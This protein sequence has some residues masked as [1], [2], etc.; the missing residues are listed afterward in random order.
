MNQRPFDFGADLVIHSVTKYLSGHSDLIQ[1]AVI[2]RDEAVFAPVKFLQNAIGATASPFDCWLTLRGLKTLS[3]RVRRH[4]E[5]ALAVA[6]A[7]E[8]HPAV[9]R[10]HYPGLASH[11]G[12]AIAKRQMTGFGGVV[13]CELRADLEATKRFVSQRRFFKLGESLGGVKSLVCHPASMTHASI[14]AETRRASG[15]PD[16]LIRLSAGIEDPLDLVE[17]LAEGLEKLGTSRAYRPKRSMIPF[18]A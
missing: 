8:R 11:P 5:N 17:D 2:A 14:P 7:L 13:S 10:V 1:G 12:H 9:A 18:E 3:L 16:G 6:E 15:L 4:N